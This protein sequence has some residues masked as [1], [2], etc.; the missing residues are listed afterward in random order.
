[1][2]LAKMSGFAKASPTIFFGKVRVNRG[3]RGK[4]GRGTFNLFVNILM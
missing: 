4:M 3:R 1:M 2:A